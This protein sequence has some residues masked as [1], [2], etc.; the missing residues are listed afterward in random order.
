MDEEDDGMIGKGNA[1]RRSRT[2]DSPAP[3][4]PSPSSWILFR[5]FE[6]DKV[7]KVDDVDSGA[8]DDDDEAA[9]VDD[10]LETFLFFLSMNA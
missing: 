4:A 6:R 2:Y 9:T 5:M 7:G 1:R 8:I 10:V 3:T